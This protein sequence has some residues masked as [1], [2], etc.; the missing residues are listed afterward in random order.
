M[1]YE[2]A[3]EILPAQLLAEVQKYAGGKLLYIPVE[4]ETKSWGEASGYR[5]KLLKRNVM[6][7]NRYK[8]GATL[9]ELA[10]EYFLSL[11]SIKKIVYGKKEKELLFEPT[12]ESAV[13]FANAGLLEEWLTLYYRIAFGRQESLFDGMICCGVVKVPLRLVENNVLEDDMS[14]TVELCMG[15]NMPLVITYQNC[16][17]ENCSPSKVYDS[18]VC[19]KVNAYPAVLMVSKAEYKQF[20]RYYGRYF[21]VV[22]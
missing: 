5:Q 9:S 16:R 15:G 6:I 18:L 22:N 4:N 11:D 2:N 10:E 8:S 21:V 20:E 17:F 13:C 1:K 19:D 3:K 14:T 7:A 12:V